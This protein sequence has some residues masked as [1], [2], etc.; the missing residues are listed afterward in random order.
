MQLFKIDKIFIHAESCTD[1]SNNPVSLI[2][3]RILSDP[4]KKPLNQSSNVS[5]QEVCRPKIKQKKNR[6]RKRTYHALKMDNMETEVLKEETEHSD[7]NQGKLALK[8]RK[9]QN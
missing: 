7:W 1:E 4:E 3:D 2:S 9:F 6:W 8:A 5:H